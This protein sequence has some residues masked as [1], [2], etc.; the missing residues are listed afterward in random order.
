MT[1]LVS[2]FWQGP[3]PPLSIRVT[4]GTDTQYKILPYVSNT[5]VERIVGGG[6]VPPYTYLATYVSGDTSIIVTDETTDTVTF[7][8]TGDGTPINSQTV[9]YDFTVTDS[10]A[11]DV[12]ERCVIT[13][14]FGLNPP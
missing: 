3:A 8:A 4:P 1:G 2:S 10:A 14:V 6:G 7:S 9:T 11:S 12:T 13:F 5:I